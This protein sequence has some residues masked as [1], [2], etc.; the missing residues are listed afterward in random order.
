VSSCIK[1]S[2]PL[3]R[4]FLDPHKILCQTCKLETI[5]CETPSR[6]TRPVI[7]LIAHFVAISLFNDATRVYFNYDAVTV[8]TTIPVTAK[9]HQ[10]WTQNINPD[11]SQTFVGYQ[12]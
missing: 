8:Y 1:H 6:L 12:C 5:A 2:T 3:K 7:D 9:G 11:G 10:H 4:L